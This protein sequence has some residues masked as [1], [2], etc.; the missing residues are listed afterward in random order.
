MIKNINRIILGLDV[1]TACLGI[2]IVSYDGNKPKLLY[3]S[4][5]KPAID[6]K[7]YK[8]AEAL[9]AKS[10]IF[11]EQ[12]SDLCNSLGINQ[13]ISDIVIEEPLLNGRN[14]WTVST[15]L[16]FNGMISESIYELTGVVP[17]YISSFDARKYAFPDLMAVRK[18]NKKG[19][20]YCYDKVKKAL[21]NNEVVLFG[22]YPFDCAK[23]MILWNKISEM[24]KDI[25]WV[26]SQKG[27]LKVENFDAS[28][29]LVCI[30]GLIGKERYENTEP[31]V[32]K[33]TETSKD[34]LKIINY[35]I[36][37]CNQYFDKTIEI[38]EGQ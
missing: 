32:T 9:F 38:E 15:L 23:K 16:K 17:Q 24:Y 26:Y 6:T 10:R 18:Y 14:A 4:H 1:S 22:N 21:E 12:F 3:I 25:Q 36:N 28:D 37:Y 5:I 27:E 11:K 34:N 29:S 2:S 7:K 13:L 30:L 8:G 35:T 31:I 19:K 20:E 33:F